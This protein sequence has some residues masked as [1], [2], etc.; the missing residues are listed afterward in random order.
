M[1]CQ[2]IMQCYLVDKEMFVGEQRFVEKFILEFME[3]YANEDIHTFR[4]ESKN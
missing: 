1:A 4:I 2:T 3:F